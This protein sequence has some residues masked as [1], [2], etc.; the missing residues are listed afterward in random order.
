M[1]GIT[2]RSGSDGG[3]KLTQVVDQLHG[4]GDVGIEV[5]AFLHVFGNMPQRLVRLAQQSAFF[6]LQGSRF[7]QRRVSG[8]YS[9][10]LPAY[11]VTSR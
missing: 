9:L 6:R 3:I 2:D 8:F 10:S 7:V 5:P 1:D 11:S 4:I